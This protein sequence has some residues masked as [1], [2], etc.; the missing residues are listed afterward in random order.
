M[1]FEHSINRE[2]IDHD[3]E[4]KDVCTDLIT[5]ELFRTKQNVQQFMFLIFRVYET[6]IFQYIDTNQL[7][8]KSIIFVYKGGNVL[9]II[10]REF[11][12]ELPHSAASYLSNFFSHFFKRS[13]ADFS[14]YI[15]PSLKNFDQVVK[16]ISSLSFEIQ[17]E[18]RDTI[19]T[20][21]QTF[22][23]FSK[24][25]HAYRNDILLD[26]F[27]KIGSLPCFYDPKNTKYYGLRPL[28]L[29]FMENQS[30]IDYDLPN[31]EGVPDKT[32]Y[33][34][35]ASETMIQ[36]DKVSGPRPI[37][38]IDNRALKYNK[39]NRLN[40]FNL[41]RTKVNFTLTLKDSSNQVV[42][43]QIP[44]ELIDV[45]IPLDD[46]CYHFFNHLNVA[47]V[48]YYLNT[49]NDVLKFTSY[50]LSYLIYDLEQMLIFKNYVPWRESKYQKRLARLVYLYF[51]EMY[52]LS[53]T[54][55]NSKKQYYLK[56]VHDLIFKNMT[57]FCITNNQLALGSCYNYIKQ[58]IE[59]Y[60]HFKFNNLLK[61]I[62]SLLTSEHVKDLNLQ[63]FIDECAIHVSNL[64]VV[65]QKMIDYDLSAH[66][67]IKESHLYT[68]NINE[69]LM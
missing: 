18:I 12:L 69:S 43:Y 19:L 4:I 61:K 23:E 58:L 27:N 39:N 46:N 52:T 31:Y 22:F 5:N 1:Q 11:Y 44:G 47:I 36:V 42:A 3:K 55:P 16:D 59:N 67:N 54:Y 65:V 9:R 7:P 24:Y 25:M 40:H 50:S 20:T 26:S 13:D 48:N 14:I 38:V 6:K 37:Y 60:P 45:S 21:P 62:Y 29:S 34:S 28:Q 33:F 63:I 53:N 64:L 35:N 30:S 56:V 57:A 15:N 8:P 66:N 49:D 17:K 10:E 32:V 51:V 2:Y 41:V 68:F